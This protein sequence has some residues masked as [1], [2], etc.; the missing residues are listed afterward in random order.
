MRAIWSVPFL[1]SSSLAAD[2]AT[3]EAIT[4]QQTGEGWHFDVTIRHADTGWDDYADG[5]RVLDMEGNILGTRIL[6]HPHVNEQPFTRSLTGVTIP[7]GI[8][9]V[10][11]ETKDS[12]GGWGGTGQVLDLRDPNYAR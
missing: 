1:M 9:E 12:V 5:W 8:T 7:A 2:P 4:A 6:H 10:Q 11:I 3:V